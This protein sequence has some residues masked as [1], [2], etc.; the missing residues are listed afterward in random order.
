MSE[1]VFMMHMLPIPFA[2]WFATPNSSDLLS[3]E[4]GVLNMVWMDLDVRISISRTNLAREK[5]EENPFILICLF[6]SLTK[7]IFG[8]GYIYLYYM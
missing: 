6:F 4:K 5:E 7:N 8:A 2:R 3:I 1:G